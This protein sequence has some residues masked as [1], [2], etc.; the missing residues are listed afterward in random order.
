MGDDRADADQLSGVAKL[1]LGGGLEACPLARI[2]FFKLQDFRTNR[3][4]FC[5]T[6]VDRQRSRC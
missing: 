6:N 1:K 2:K 3:P 4:P 5:E